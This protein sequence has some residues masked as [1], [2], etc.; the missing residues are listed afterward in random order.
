[1]V[2]GGRW[3][4]VVN[5]HI[6]PHFRNLYLTDTYSDYVCIHNLDSSMLYA[7]IGEADVHVYCILRVCINTA[8]VLC[9]Y[10]EALWLHYACN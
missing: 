6:Q 5:K 4:W 7:Y 1:M 3:G 8:A 2:V 10:V 9:V